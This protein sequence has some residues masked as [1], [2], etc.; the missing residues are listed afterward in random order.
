MSD[1]IWKIKKF[2]SWI[3]KSIEYAWFLREDED[4][5][6]VFIY[7]LL[8]YK[9][10][11][12][13]ECIIKNDY[14]EGTKRIERQIKYAE[15]LIEIVKDGYTATKMREAHEV[16]WG[17]LDFLSDKTEKNGNRITTLTFT[18][19]KDSKDLRKANKEM[20]KIY[21]LERAKQ[22]QLKTRLFRH[23]KT[24]LHHWWD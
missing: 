12:T 24:Y 4:W 18:K 13:R 22:E 6:Y 23:L 14:I 15:Y 11:R 16:K 9:L 1:F 21:E 8:A 3:K 5:D 7:N 20:R 19:V 10:K 2:F 17:R